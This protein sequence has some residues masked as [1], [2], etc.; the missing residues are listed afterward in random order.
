MTKYNTKEEIMIW[1]MINSHL[2]SL[3]TRYKFVDWFE[4]LFSFK[5]PSY[6]NPMDDTYG[7]KYGSGF[8]YH[9][10]CLFT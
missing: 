7:Y 2:V 6:L 8:M 4:V 3:M 10:S 5:A 1:Q 9:E